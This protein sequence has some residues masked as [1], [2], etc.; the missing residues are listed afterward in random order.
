MKHIKIAL[1]VAIIAIGK[2]FIGGNAF[3]RN[4][5]PR[6]HQAAARMAILLK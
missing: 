6:L 2:T 5:L 4:H 1:M 3:A